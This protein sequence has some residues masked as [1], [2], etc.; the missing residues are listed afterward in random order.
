M[1]DLVVRARVP[2]LA[3]QTDEAMLRTI[4][5]LLRDWF[6]AGV[7]VEREIPWEVR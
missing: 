2:N 3:G 5:R 7:V 4:E 6:G 1:A